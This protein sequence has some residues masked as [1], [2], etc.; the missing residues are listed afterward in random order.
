M[1]HHHTFQIYRE[2]SFR[3]IPSSRLRERKFVRLAAQAASELKL[4]R[5]IIAPIWSLADRK[6]NWIPD[7]IAFPCLRQ[8]NAIF[9][10]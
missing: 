5:C 7:K 1:G 10:E 9:P 6:P 2:A 8:E 4:T 3:K